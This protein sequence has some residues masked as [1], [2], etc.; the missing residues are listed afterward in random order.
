M[1]TCDI[2]IRN[3]TL[4]YPEGMLSTD[5]AVDGGSIA[6]IGK[7]HN[8]VTPQR[9]IDATGK[10]VL[11]GVVDSHV[12]MEQE[13][14]GSV[15]R[16]SFETGSVAG[17]F[18]G[19]TT[20]IDFVFQPENQSPFQ[21]I[22]K[23]R[24][25]ASRAVVDYSFHFVPAVQKETPVDFLQDL[26]GFGLPSVKLFLAYRKQGIMADDAMFFS[27]LSAASKVNAIVGIHSEN[28]AIA[29]LLLDKYLREGKCGPEYFPESRP[30]FVEEE[31]TC[32][33]LLLAQVTGTKLHI[34]HMST[35]EGVTAV[36]NARNKG[37]G[38][39]SETCP[40]YLT[41]TD[42]R[43]SN[44]DGANYIVCPPLR[45][46]EDSEELWRGLAD[47]T[48]ATIGTDHSGWQLSD[49]KMGKESF[50]K[51]MPG[52]PGIE[53][54]LPIL[55]SE[56]VSKGRITVSRLVETMSTNPARIF[57]LYPRKG[58]LLPGSDADIVLLDPR[59]Q[60][61]ISIEDLHSSVD[62]TPYEGFE[63]KGAPIMTISK[64]KVVV[65][66]GQFCGNAG[67]GEFIKR[68]L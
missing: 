39:T 57:G 38:V 22:S 16:E 36:R 43:Y 66:D 56:G 65:E 15:P 26:I 42:A 27:A 46:K 48:I 29:E 64:G 19:V 34:F 20:F 8:S 41:L 13:W 31:A 44:S 63:V 62:Y 59:L 6:L 3:G 45:K 28:G 60:K 61:R 30:N 25:L 10:L 58:G 37:F 9:T 7:L 47:G 4:V 14:S 21:S 5:I 54:S 18:G 1:S 12:H 49:K 40:H 67:D 11:P 17:A 2:L 23:R 33:A 24:D 52:L 51:A 55:Y 50:D 53:T 68:C 35:K 32:R